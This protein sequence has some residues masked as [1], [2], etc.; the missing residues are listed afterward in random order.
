MRGVLDTS[1]FTAD[2]QQRELAT[3]DLP[4]D[5]PISPVTLAEL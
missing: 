5:A 3:A 2:E 4:D 1:V